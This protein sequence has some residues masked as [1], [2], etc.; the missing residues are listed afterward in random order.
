VLRAAATARPPATSPPDAAAGTPADGATDGMLLLGGGEFLMGSDNRDGF[1]ADGEGPVRRVTLSPF[2]ID[3]VALSNVRFATFVEATRHVTEAE[4]YSWSFVFGGLLPDDFSP[5]RGAAQ[6]P[7]WRQVFG[8]DWRHPEGPGSSVDD[9]MDHPVVRRLVPHR[10]PSQR[11]AVRASQGDPVRLL[12]LPPLLLHPLPGGR[13]QL[14]HP[15]QLHRQHGVPRRPR[16]LNGR[17]RGRR[18]TTHQ[19]IGWRAGARRCRRTAQAS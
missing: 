14:Q 8:A 11:A 9:R 4:R 18:A 16:R 17:L 7:W 12:S 10:L 19:L 3:P 6:A 13:P 15:R 5:T 1:A 2:W